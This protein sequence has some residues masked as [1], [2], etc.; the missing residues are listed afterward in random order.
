MWNVF[1]H[2]RGPEP[3]W[4]G[5]S[6]RIL[7]SLSM[8]YNIEERYLAECKR[9]EVKVQPAGKRNWGFTATCEGIAS[10][11]QKYCQRMGIQAEGPKCDQLKRVVTL[12]QYCFSVFQ[13][14][15]FKKKKM[16]SSFQVCWFENL[17]FNRVPQRQKMMGTTDL[18]SPKPWRGS[19]LPSPVSPKK[20]TPRF[21]STSMRLILTG[22]YK[23][24][25]GLNTELSKQLVHSGPFSL[26]Y[27][28]KLWENAV[29]S[30]L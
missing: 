11:M 24:Q 9:R 5:S 4:C 7:N 8:R 23:S 6:D 28:K 25:W 29:S 10:K 14:F 26:V 22:T 2:N 1:L 18:E 21:T 27:F 19:A 12:A 15:P 16:L 3:L 20:P 30:T 17:E 13:Y